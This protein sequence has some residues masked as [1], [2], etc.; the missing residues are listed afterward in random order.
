[1]C[2]DTRWFL[3]WVNPSQ[4]WGER[5]EGRQYPLLAEPQIQWSWRCH[6]RVL[7]KPRHVQAVPD[8]GR[9]AVL[10][11][12]ERS[13]VNQTKVLFSFLAGANY[14]FSW[15]SWFIKHIAM[16]VGLVVKFLIK[17]NSFIYNDNPG[18][19]LNLSALMIIKAL[20]PKRLDYFHSSLNSFYK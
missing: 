18:T 14:K 17:W 3:R 10:P 2:W 16:V 15:S 11:G 9:D 20:V 6:W 1:M 5:E 13:K 7:S 19:E 4:C 12:K 8:V